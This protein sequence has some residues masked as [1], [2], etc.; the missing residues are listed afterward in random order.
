[1]DS[2]DLRCN[3]PLARK[4]NGS[5]FCK[6]PAGMGTTH[7]GVGHC[8]IHGGD[9]KPDKGKKKE[10]GPATRAR[11]HVPLLEQAARGLHVEDLEHLYDMSNKGLV[12]AR[13]TAVQRL[14]SGQITT[15]EASDLSITIQ[16]IDKVLDAVGFETEDNP[17]MPSN[18]GELDELDK[19]LARLEALEG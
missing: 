10:Q 16:R 13:A 14:L 4:K 9:P 6:Q 1:M 2:T 11:L 19:E 17:D 3:A 12:L 5:K 15:K 8:V 7:E 18:T